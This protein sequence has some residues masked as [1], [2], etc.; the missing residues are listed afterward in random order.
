MSSQS[1]EAVSLEKNGITYVDGLKN[2]A[3]QVT[4]DELYLVK[5]DL[6]AITAVGELPTE[7]SV[8]IPDGKTL[9]A[10]GLTIGAGEVAFAE[11]GVELAT[12]DMTVTGA[13]DETFKLVS[14]GTATGGSSVTLNSYSGGGGQPW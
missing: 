13:T 7:G 9:V 4:F 5:A 12:D 8:I 6:G 2:A 14:G 1:D 11:D 10:A 3:V